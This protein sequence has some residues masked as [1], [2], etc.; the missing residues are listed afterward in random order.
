M[1]LRS[2]R[3]PPNLCIH[4]GELQDPDL[5]RSSIGCLIL[6]PVALV[7]TL[8]F[9]SL[10]FA[11]GCFLKPALNIK[12]LDKLLA[13]VAAIDGLGVVTIVHVQQFRGPSAQHLAHPVAVFLMYAAIG[14]KSVR[15]MGIYALILGSVLNAV[16]A[17]FVTI[18]ILKLL[19]SATAQR[20]ITK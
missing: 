3:P 1:P 7:T 14:A 9:G 15:G 12:D 8:A 17:S 19:P 20:H 16:V 4:C 13:L 11:A 5:P 6:I 2:F 18:G 10:G